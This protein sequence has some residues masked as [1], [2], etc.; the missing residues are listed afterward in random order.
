MPSTSRQISGFFLQKKMGQKKIEL[1]ARPWHPSAVP[2][3]QISRDEPIQ[4]PEK[5]SDIPPPDP[6][7]FGAPPPPK[8]VMEALNQRLER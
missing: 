8:T 1:V 3:R 6:S 7:M 5:E 4:M 2:E